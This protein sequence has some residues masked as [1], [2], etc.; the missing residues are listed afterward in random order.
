MV[1]EILVVLDSFAHQSIAN[2]KQWA[3]VQQIYTHGKVLDLC[4][5]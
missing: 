2:S 3:W 1:V 4:A 5:S